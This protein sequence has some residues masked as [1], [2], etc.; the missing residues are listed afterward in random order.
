MIRR[1]GNAAE[2]IKQGLEQAR[3]RNMLTT[4]ATDTFQSIFKEL[5][6][7]L[8]RINEVAESAQQMTERNDAMIG[9]VTQLSAISEE[10]MASTEEVASLAGNLADLADKL[11]QSTNMFR[12]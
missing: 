1:S 10:G 9:A 5:G 12:I 8:N 2:V 4:Q 7:G 6:E 3:E 11:K